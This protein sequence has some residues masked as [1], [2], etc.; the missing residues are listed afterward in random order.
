MD[1]RV[2]L[3]AIATETETTFDTALEYNL[4]IEFE[5]NL[6]HVTQLWDKSTELTGKKRSLRSAHLPSVFEILE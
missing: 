6:Q 2:F 3:V 5:G 4:C 1:L